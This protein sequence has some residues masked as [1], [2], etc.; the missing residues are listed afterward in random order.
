[1]INAGASQ[2]LTKID[3]VETAMIPMG[4]RRKRGAIIS[5]NYT[6]EDTLSKIIYFKTNGRPL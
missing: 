3:A 5:K 4:R 6:I 2:S 1:M